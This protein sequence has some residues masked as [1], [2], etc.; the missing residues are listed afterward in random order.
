MNDKLMD[1]IE[2]DIETQLAMINASLTSDDRAEEALPNIQEALELLY[3][4]L[5]LIRQEL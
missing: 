3:A 5:K 1:D 2:L 4:Y